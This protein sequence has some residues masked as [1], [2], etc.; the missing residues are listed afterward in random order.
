ARVERTFRLP[1]PSG[2]R[3]ASREGCEYGRRSSASQRT[4]AGITVPH[5]LQVRFF[6]S[7][8]NRS[9]IGGKSFSTLPRVKNSSY[10]REVQ[11]SQYHWSPSFSCGSRLRSTTRPTE[12]GIRWGECGTRGGR[13]KI[14]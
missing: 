13:R 9:K 8:K 4:G 6:S 10:S 11:L 14:S 7:A 1:A 5:F 12:F 2:N 3:A